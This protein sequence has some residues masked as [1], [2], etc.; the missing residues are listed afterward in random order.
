MPARKPF[1]RP[2]DPSAP[3]RRAEALAA[4]LTDADL[5]GPAYRQLLW[6]VHITASALTITPR[7]TLITHHTAAEL[8]GGVVPPTAGCQ[9]R[10]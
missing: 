3:F 7:G 6:G 8:W 4:G 9:A 10:S 1:N 5:A 2:F